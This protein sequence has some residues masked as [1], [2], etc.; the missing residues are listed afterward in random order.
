MNG[1]EWSLIVQTQG[2]EPRGSR[3]KHM[4][5]HQGMG[6]ER[7]DKCVSRPNVPRSFHPRI[8]WPVVGVGPCLKFPQQQHK[9]NMNEVVTAVAIEPTYRDNSPGFCLPM[10][11]ELSPPLWVQHVSREAQCGALCGI[12]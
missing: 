9:G 12:L 2:T 5:G 8:I 7:E 6:V 3:K 11:M 10:L 1:S 4:H